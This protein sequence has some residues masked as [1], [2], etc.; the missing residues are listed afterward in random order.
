M[1]K[2]LK[3][4]TKEERLR[5]LTLYNYARLSWEAVVV[6]RP[7]EYLLACEWRDFDL[8]LSVMSDIANGRHS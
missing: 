1:D 7:P 2:D 4:L 3:S 5:F 8:S 6:G